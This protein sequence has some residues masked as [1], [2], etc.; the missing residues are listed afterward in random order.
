MVNLLRR[1]RFRWPW[2]VVPEPELFDWIREGKGKIY[3]P[4]HHVDCN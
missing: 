1:L 3:Q 2:Y 4:E